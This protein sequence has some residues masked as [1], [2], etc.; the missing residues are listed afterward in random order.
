MEGEGVASVVLEVLV[1]L[2]ILHLQL[3]QV[4]LKLLDLRLEGFEV[5]DVVVEVR[6]HFIELTHQHVLIFFAAQLELDVRR[7]YFKFLALAC[8]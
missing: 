1:D 5:C 3:I 6:L 4:I 7:G 8:C 2:L